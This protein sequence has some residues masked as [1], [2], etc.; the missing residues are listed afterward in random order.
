ML[1]EPPA[2][3]WMLGEGL[4][5]V[6]EILDH[7]LGGGWIFLCDEIEQLGGPLQSGVGPEDAEAHSA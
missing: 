5:T 6:E 7:P 4:C 1:R 3:A 2:E